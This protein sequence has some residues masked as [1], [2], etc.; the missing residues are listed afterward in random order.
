[1]DVFEQTLHC[2]THKRVDIFYSQFMFLLLL[3]SVIWVPWYLDLKRPIL[4][5]PGLQMLEMEKAHLE[6][7]PKSRIHGSIHPLPYT[8]SWRSA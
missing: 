6:L 7:V 4:P 1:M 2:N 5:A 8:P 3:G